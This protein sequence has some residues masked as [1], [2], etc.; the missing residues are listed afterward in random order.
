MQNKVMKSN[1]KKTLQFLVIIIQFQWQ[2][3]MMSCKSKVVASDALRFDTD[4][5]SYQRNA[6]QTLHKLPDAK[7]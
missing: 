6:Q 2:M 7:T 3:K 5:C 1:K 4:G